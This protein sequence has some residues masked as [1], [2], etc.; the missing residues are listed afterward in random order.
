MEA[1]LR[2]R[3]PLSVLEPNTDSLVAAV[4][5][6]VDMRV[7]FVASQRSKEVGAALHSRDR[8][9]EAVLGMTEAGATTTEVLS[10]LVMAGLLRH[11]EQRL[12]RVPG[13]GKYLLRRSL[14]YELVL[15]SDGEVTYE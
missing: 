15:P 1:T 10:G 6:P 12:R 8:V 7:D 13:L 5:P 14:P 4:D 2:A 11:R 3:I 9:G